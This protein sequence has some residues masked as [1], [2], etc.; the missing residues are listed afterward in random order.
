VSDEFYI[1]YMKQAPA[2]LARFIRAR[3]VLALTIAAIVAGALAAAQ[4]PIDSGK[5]EFGNQRSFEG[6]LL[7]DPIP[8]LLMNAPGGHV[9]SVLVV[10]AGKF[11]IPEYA[12]AGV[13]QKV[14]FEG[15]LIYR[16][17]MTMIEMNNPTSFEVRGPQ[18]SHVPSIVETL[19]AVSLTGELVDTKCYFGVMRPGEGKVH[20]ACAVICLRGGIPPGLLLHHG[21]GRATVVML[22]PAGEDTLPVDPEWAARHIT[23][24]GNLEIVDGILILKA[25]S[26]APK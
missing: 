14:R 10:N 24:T 7:S 12:A 9:A 6:V 4:R 23:A 16:Q 1:G 15:T 2:L 26:V 21:D 11:G 3:T 18:E 8:R 17:N 5:F 22:A 13:N 25:Q 20:R 19:G